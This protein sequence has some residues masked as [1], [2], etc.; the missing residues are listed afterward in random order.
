MTP[1]HS[2]KRTCVPHAAYLSVEA[3]EKRLPTRAVMPRRRGGE[4]TLGIPARAS[5]PLAA[6]IIPTV[7]AALVGT[8]LFGSVQPNQP[9]HPTRASA[10]A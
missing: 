7:I 3:V 2:F 5:L 4:A 9:L 1:D 10:R 8:D 6:N